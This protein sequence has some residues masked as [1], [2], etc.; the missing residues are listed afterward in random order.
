MAVL[1]RIY[2][3]LGLALSDAI[4][5]R[6]ERWRAEN[7]SGARGEHRYSAADF[8]LSPEAI[9]EDY[10]FYLRAFDVEK[11]PERTKP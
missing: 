11:G 10:D 6:F 4:R 8:G 9:R 3:W 5:S 2:D 1:E 7:A